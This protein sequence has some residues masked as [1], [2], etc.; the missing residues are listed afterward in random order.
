LTFF[1]ILS[2]KFVNVTIK[3]RS[4]ATVDANAVTAARAAD[5]ESVTFTVAV[6]SVPRIAAASAASEDN[7]TDSL[8][9]PAV[10]GMKTVYFFVPAAVPAVALVAE[11]VVI[12][13]AVSIVLDKKALSVTIP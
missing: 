9:G 8:T 13:V 5:P 10:V 3:V 4:E 6:I 12:V 11:A 2:T 1:W 7:V